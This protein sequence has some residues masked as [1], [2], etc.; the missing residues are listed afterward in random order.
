M[1]TLETEILFALAL[2]RDSKETAIAVARLIADAVRTLPISDFQIL[3]ISHLGRTSAEYTFGPTKHSVH[4]ADSSRITTD[5]IDGTFLDRGRLMKF[6]Q[7]TWFG[8]KFFPHIWHEPKFRRR[9]A[10]PRE[11]LATIE[12]V[13]WLGGFWCDSIKEETVINGYKI[14]G[15]RKDVDWRFQCI[16]GSLMRWINLEV[17]RR[18][19]DIKGLLIGGRKVFDP[20]AD[21][22]EKFAPSSEDEINVAAI[23]VF[24]SEASKVA[25]LGKQWLNEPANHNVDCL[26]VCNEMNS[27]A[28]YCAVDSKQAKLRD[29]LVFLDPPVATGQFPILIRHPVEVP[30]VPTAS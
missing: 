5:G 11:H 2:E 22:S 23:T 25:E 9:L 6:A 4:N 10:N 27:A 21:I 16:S 29:L 7:A 13:V 19:G 18:D 26:I 12:E 14:A 24:G 20:F 28:A 17:K 15:R 30:G 3:Q 1:A 8:E